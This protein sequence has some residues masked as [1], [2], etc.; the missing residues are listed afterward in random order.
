VT[1][2]A[3]DGGTPPSLKKGYKSPELSDLMRILRVVRSFTEKPKG[4]NST[5]TELSRENLRVLIKFLTM[6]GDTK[7][8]WR[9]KGWSVRA[10]VPVA[11]IGR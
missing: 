11:T 7:T 6:W 5:E 10:A 3:E 9:W 4:S 2:R 8:L 1:V